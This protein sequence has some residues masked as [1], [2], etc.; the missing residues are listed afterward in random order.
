MRVFQITAAIAVIALFN[1]S[2]WTTIVVKLDLP[3]LVEQS[4]TIIQ[5]QVQQTESRWD[6]QMKLIFTDVWV[7]VSDALKGAPQTNITGVPS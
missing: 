1:V 3:E 2:G 6:N 4:D 7:R 5:G